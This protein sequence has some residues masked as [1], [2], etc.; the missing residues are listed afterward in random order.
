MRM[1]RKYGSVQNL[2]EI[3]REL[4]FVVSTVNTTLKDAARVKD[5]LRGK[6]MMKLMTLRKKRKGAISEIEKLLSRWTLTYRNM[7]QTSLMAIQAMARNSSEDL[8]GKYSDAL[9]S[10]ASSSS[11]FSRFEARSGFHKCLER[12]FVEMNL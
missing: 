12:L 10:F 8:K 7:F 6:A 2:R 11:W 5:H 4:D 9:Q 1:I 3:A